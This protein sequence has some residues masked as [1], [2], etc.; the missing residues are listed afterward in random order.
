MA[1]IYLHIPFCKQ[2]CHYCDFHFSTQV[3]SMSDLLQAM[4]RELQSRKHYLEGE[5]IE[6]IYFGG[7]TPSLL[8]TDDIQRILDDIYK[9]FN[10]VAQPE[11]TLE[12]NPDD[13]T[14]HKIIELARTPVNRLSIGIQSF[15]SQDLQWMNRAHTTAQA[16]FSVKCAQDRG[17]ENITIDLIYSIPGLSERDWLENIRKAVDLQVQHISAYSLTIEPKTA[18]G[19]QLAKQ[20]LQPVDDQISG[21]QFIALVNELK[22]CGFEQYEVS[23]FCLPGMQSKHNSAYWLGKNYLGIGPSAH[24]FNGTSRQ[25]NVANNPRYSKGW[26]NGIPEFE[27]ETLDDRTRLNEY[28]MTRLRTTW[29]IELDYIQHAFG[30]DLWQTENDLLNQL[31]QDGLMTKENS[32]LTLTTTGLLQADRIASEL[33]ILET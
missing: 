23:N 22:R 1:G 4:R 10:I 28:L 18:F 7:G 32:T 33:F 5:T 12:A 26:M 3:K 27:I 11:I 21:T 8:P 19:N 6:T 2:A 15:R 30:V 25:W 13:L 31:I 16:D 9:H 24:S 17:F 29:G 20:E 14:F